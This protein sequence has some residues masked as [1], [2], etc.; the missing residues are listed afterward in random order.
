VNVPNG[1]WIDEEGMIVRPAEPAW[2]GKSMWREIVKIPDKLPDDLDPFLRKSLEM[3]AKVKSDPAKYL[4]ALRDWAEKGSDSEYA[5]TPDEVMARSGGRSTET[6]E[7]R[8]HFEIG[9]Y[10]QKNGQSDDAVEH[11]KIAHELEPEN[12]TYKRQAWQYVSPLLQDARAVYGTGWADE[13]EKFGPE[14]YYRPHDF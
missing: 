10:L 13:V 8:A 6:S 2:P 7:A 4:T 9:Q 12:W 5:L 1:V 3:S 14:N 11:F